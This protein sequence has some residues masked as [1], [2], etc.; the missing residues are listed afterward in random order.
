MFI[1][2]PIRELCLQ[3]KPPPRGLE[4]QSHPER[5]S[6]ALPL[7]T[8]GAGVINCWEHE[9]V[10]LRSGWKLHVDYV[11]GKVSWGCSLTSP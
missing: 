1:L 4:G 8:N 6:Q 7:G 11:R 2:R 10:T 3:G 9:M 5:H